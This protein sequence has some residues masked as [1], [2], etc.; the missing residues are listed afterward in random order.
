MRPVIVVRTA[1]CAF[2]CFAAI[3]CKAPPLI[4][5]LPYDGFNPATD[6]GP[7]LRGPVVTTNTDVY[8]SF[9]TGLG[10][11]FM[12]DD[13]ILGIN[14]TNV[15]GVTVGLDVL[16]DSGGKPGVGQPFA[17]LT[18]T[19]PL[20]VGDNQLTFTP[21]APITLNNTTTYW[22]ELTGTLPSGAV[23][24]WDN[25]GN[26]SGVSSFGWTENFNS[27]TG[28]GGA[29]GP[30]VALEID[31]IQVPEPSSLSLLALGLAGLRFCRRR[32]VR[33]GVF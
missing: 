22:L 23:V 2:F 3:N 1:L 30:A 25:V 16:P 32:I 20:V 31:G 6:T 19:G 8:V 5:S 4:S 26:V 29:T 28:L 12:V 15:T 10:G 14:V 27:L 9:T 17:S 11:P 33:Q 13:I 18:N 7:L 24:Q 21:I